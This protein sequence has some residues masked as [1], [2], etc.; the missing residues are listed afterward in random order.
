MVDDLG[1]G[2]GDR[3]VVQLR[4][5]WQ[6]V[7]LTLACLRAGVVP[8]MALP[9][10]RRHEMQ[11]LVDHS[12]AVAVA[13]PGELRGFD[14]ERMAAELV[15]S[16]PTLTTVLT[17]AGDP[18]EDSIALDSLCAAGEGRGD[19]QRWDA[20]APDPARR[21]RLPALRWHDRSA[22]ADRPHAQRLLLQRARERRAV[23][24]RH[25]HRLP[26][27]VARI[28][29]LP[30]GLPR[31]PRGAAVRRPGRHAAVARARAC[32]RHDRR[33]RCHRHRGG[34]RGGA[35]VDGA[36]PESYGAGQLAPSRCCRSAAPASPTRSPGRSGR[37]WAAPCSRCSAWPRGC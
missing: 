14:H 7:V 24:V 37:C 1:F 9:A 10:H 15:Q 31:N 26:G 20:A 2:T 22:Q 36:T 12:E 28:A 29:Q 8:V 19:R 13:V 27:R 23:R 17:T 16:C 6:F 32:V 4:N 3:I 34:A 25:R 35:A 18:R 21:R 5:C 30:A 11:Y 33:G